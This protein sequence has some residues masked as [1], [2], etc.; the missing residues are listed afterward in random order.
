[1][2]LYITHL[3]TVL[4]SSRSI[5]NYIFGVRF[6]HKQLDLTP[7]AVESFPVQCLL[8][9]VDLTMRTPPRRKL[10]ILPHLVTQLCG[11]PACLGSLGPAMKVC[12]TFFFLEMLR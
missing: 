1:M 10:P 12:L 4:T 5:R 9:A 3:S 7:E 6:L 8:R 11:L 2:C